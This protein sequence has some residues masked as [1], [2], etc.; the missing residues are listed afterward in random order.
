MGSSSETL[1]VH[2]DECVS[3]GCVEVGTVLGMEARVSSAQ[4]ALAVNLARRRKSFVQ[5]EMFLYRC[6]RGSAKVRV[7][8]PSQNGSTHR[9][10]KELAPGRA[11][12]DKRVGS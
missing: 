5:G 12:F 2:E 9:R 8:I 11:V 1:H 4:S 6:S 3:Q 7:S 10:L